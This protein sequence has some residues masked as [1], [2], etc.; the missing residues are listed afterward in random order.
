MRRKLMLLLLVLAVLFVLVGCP[1]SSIDELISKMKFLDYAFADG[2]P[3]TPA[4]ALY[5][6]RVKADDVLQVYTPV[7][8]PK[9]GEFVDNSIVI[10]PT[11]GA[12]G[13]LYYL[14]LDPGAFYNH[15]G[16]VVVLGE[17]GEPIIDEEVQG[18]PVLNGETPEPLV[19]PTMKA[20]AKAIFWRNIRYK[21]T[22]IQIP[23]WVIIPRVISGAVVVNGL[24]PTQNLYTEASNIHNMMYEA[25]V[26]F[27]VADKVKQVE[28][29]DNAPS[30]V[31][32]AIQYLVETKKVNSITLYFIAHGSYDR[33]NIGG[34][35][36]SASDLKN[37]IE[38]YSS[39]KFFII[40][41]SCHSGSWI[42]GITNIVDP[43]NVILAITTTT[44][45]KSAYSDWDSAAGYTDDYNGTIDVYIEWT[46]DFLQMMS[47]YTG[48]A[49]SEVT[50]Y[51]EEH[52]IPNEAALYDLCFLS[53]K[54]GS[55]PETSYTFT[56][57]V[58]IQEPRIYRSY[59]P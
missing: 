42:E 1:G 14:D 20:Y 35:S 22:E 44:A 40:I 4:V 6:G 2:E 5:L 25:M 48:P 50:D 53:I 37:I 39:V 36:F 9:S 32:D 34:H 41:E 24:T 51:A 28:Y 7:P 59:S 31:E 54:A 43:E 27:M 30:D 47:Y 55:P 17:D 26:D 56:E 13:Y 18:W 38:S 52:D 46:S 21:I 19:S 58:G 11:I 10:A 45:D 49:W 12:P 16:R 57:R 3:E 23:E 15:P 8:E 29:P 33:M